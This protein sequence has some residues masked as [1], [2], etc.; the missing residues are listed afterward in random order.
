MASAESDQ[1]NDGED[2]EIVVSLLNL[3]KVDGK[4]WNIALFEDKMKITACIC[5]HCKSVCRDAVELGCDHE[6]DEI[7]TYCEMCLS[8]LVEDSNGK[9]PIDGH[10]NPIIF[11]SRAMRRQISKSTVICPYSEEFKQINDD[12][13]KDKLS[14]NQSVIDTPGNNNDNNQN[15]EG[16][17]E[18]MTGNING[19]IWKGTLIDLIK[20]K[21]LKAC[22]SKY[23]P[24]F[25]SDITIH[26]LRQ[27]LKDKEHQIE[28]QMNNIN[29]INNVI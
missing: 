19:C 8:N 28:E 24:T 22:T 13:A 12:N 26:K 6:D 23:N 29:T 1:K 16:Y 15:K 17:V 2:V 21:H 4:G 25:F 3:L 14:H 7:F 10:E 18:G 11:A 5:H 20:S 27:R 9:C